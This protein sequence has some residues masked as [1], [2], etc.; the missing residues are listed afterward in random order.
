MTPHELIEST[1]PDLG[2]KAS[3]RDGCVYT[4]PPGPLAPYG[5]TVRLSVHDGRPAATT[6]VNHPSGPVE[7]VRVFRRNGAHKVAHV[8][9]QDIQIMSGVHVAATTGEARQ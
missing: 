1:I 3:T 5:A 6:R 9:K 4:L 8:V 2:V 7:R